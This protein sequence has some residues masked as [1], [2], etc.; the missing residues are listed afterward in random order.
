MSGR[1]QTAQYA[2][3]V[4]LCLAAGVAAGW[5]AI[6]AGFDNDVH[7]FLYRMHAPPAAESES[8][9]LAIDES[10]WAAM[11]GQRNL[12]RTIAETLE[13]VNRAAPSAVVVDVL[14]AGAGD[15]PEDDARLEAAF[16]A[17]RNLVLASSLTPRGWEEPYEPF[18]RRAA[19]VGH[20]HADPDVHDHVVRRV[21]L[22]KA[23]GRD[24]RWAVAL[25]AYRLAR[26]AALEESPGALRIG[27]LEIPLSRSN[28]RSM[29]VRFRAPGENGGHT[30][31][32]VS[33]D[34]LKRRPELAS[35]L[36]GKVVFAGF[37]A[38]GQDR[39]TTPVSAGGT[40]P[41]VEIHA[42]AFETLA[43]GRFLRPMPDTAS[44]AFCVLIALA[45]AAAFHFLSGWPAYLAGAAILAASH[46]APYGLWRADI[47]F[48]VTAPL[49]AGWLTIA[50]AASFQHFVVRRR[51]RQTERDRERYQ[52]AIR[53]VAHEMRSPLAAIQG[54]SELMGRYALPE[55]KRRQITEMINSES[56]RMARMMQTF[57]DVERL[58]EGQMELRRDTWP[59]AELVRACVERARP[60]AERKQIALRLEAMDDLAVTGDRELM[61]YAVYNLLSNAIKYSPASTEVRVSCAR[62]G[63][64]ARIAV[65]DQGIGMDEKEV[66]Q[67]FRKFY[68]TK[69]AEASGETGAG[70]G[71]A[72]VEQI[73]A[74]HGGSVEVESAPGAGSCFTILAPAAAHATERR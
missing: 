73:V 22:E 27:A 23:Q 7:D 65:R 42:N 47:V 36:A 56:K 6:G 2:G 10:T 1:K 16:A 72:I 9:I 54:S 3:L 69:K 13:I 39:H 50:G 74:H 64:R 29:V 12:R 28:A 61:E 35:R 60:L 31:P 66:K 11:G 24:R 70:I 8:A 48:P 19:A 38:Q 68:R 57:L 40:M 55:A 67:I 20:V 46:A 25:E 5:S 45:A 63:G 4:A 53:F 43:G 18:A 59:A 41:G 52:Q 30:V 33:I 37:T 21:P 49:S 71:L 15:R 14:L 62:D 17:T 51:L 58:S 26:A 32:H 44:L 34:E